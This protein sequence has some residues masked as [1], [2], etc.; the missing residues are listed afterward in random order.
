MNAIA[1]RARA[2]E[3]R[4]VTVT[5][6]GVE[7]EPHPITGRLGHVQDVYLGLVDVPGRDRPT[8]R[9]L[10]DTIASIDPAGRES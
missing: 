8:V 2:L 4:R 3:G 1:D 5:L 10:L 6:A 9:I 7:S